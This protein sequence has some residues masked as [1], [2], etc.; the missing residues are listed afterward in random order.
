MSQKKSVL[1][2]AEVFG[3]KMLVICAITNLLTLLESLQGVTPPPE[4][5]KVSL[6]RL[7][8]SS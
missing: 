8:L 7:S 6:G 5:L 2:D 3:W 1:N 4:G